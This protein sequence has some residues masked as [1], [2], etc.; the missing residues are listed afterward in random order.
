MVVYCSTYFVITL[1]GGG[2]LTLSLSAARIVSAV[3]IIVLLLLLRATAEH[4]ENGGRGDGLL[5]GGLG[6]LDLGLG[7]LGGAHLESRV[8]VGWWVG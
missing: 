1:G 4:G 2:G 6:L 7:V 8:V 5:L 3:L